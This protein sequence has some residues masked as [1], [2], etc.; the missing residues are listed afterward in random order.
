[1][2]MMYEIIAQELH[3]ANVENSHP[4]DYLNFYCLGNREKY[5]KNEPDAVSQPPNSGTTVVFMLL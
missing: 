2:K 4:Q 5:D 1:M 3:Y